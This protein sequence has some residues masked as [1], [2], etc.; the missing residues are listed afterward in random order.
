MPP[1]PCAEP[2]PPAMRRIFASIPETWTDQLGLR[3]FARVG[4]I[5]A[6]RY[7]EKITSR[8]ASHARDDRG[9]RAVVAKVSICF[10]SAVATVS[11]SLTIGTTPVRMRA[12]KVLWMFS[13]LV[14]VHNV[15]AREQDLSHVD[16]VFQEHFVVN[17]HQLAL[18]DRSGGLLHGQL[19]G[20]LAQAELGGADADRAG[21]HKH[22]FKPP[23][24]G[25]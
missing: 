17:V 9:K 11:F 1:V 13:T 15:F 10:S 3:V 8:S 21:R 18:A 5:T 12:V 7:P 19:G 25:R 24:L 2:A 14:V 20:A 16:A 23:V 6:R 4:I 22:H